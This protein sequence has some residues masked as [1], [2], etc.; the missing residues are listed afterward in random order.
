[1]LG[2]FSPWKEATGSGLECTAAGVF[3]M[4]RGSASSP[5]PW[6]SVRDIWIVRAWRTEA[7]PS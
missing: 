1:M 4:A 6:P 3:S 2:P 7:S 5:R